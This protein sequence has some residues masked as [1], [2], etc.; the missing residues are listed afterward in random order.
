MTVKAMRKVVRCSMGLQ[1]MYVDERQEEGL[2]TDEG[3]KDTVETIK[4]DESSVKVGISNE[5][6]WGS[7]L[8]LSTQ[9]ATTEPGSV[10]ALSQMNRYMK[11][12]G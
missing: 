10:A 9:T 11:Q 3:D 5:L 4:G 8:R 12:K 2:G 1:I 6:M 7:R